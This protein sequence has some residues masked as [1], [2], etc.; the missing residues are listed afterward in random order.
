MGKPR[1]LKNT[2]GMI[3][4]RRLRGIKILELDGHDYCN[5]S[6]HQIALDNDRSTGPLL[7]E[8]LLQP[9]LPEADV[10]TTIA[11]SRVT[12]KLT[13]VTGLPE[14]SSPRI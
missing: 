13:N 4:L 12:A 10:S 1:C 8:E 14:E 6:G 9:R 11:M 5:K 3:D 2:E 7:R